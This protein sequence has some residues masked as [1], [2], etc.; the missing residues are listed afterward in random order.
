MRFSFWFL[1]IGMILAAP[2]MAQPAACGAERAS[3]EHEM[4][5]ARSK[6]QMLQRRQLAER[7][8]TLPAD[9]QPAH[10]DPSHA[11]DIKRLEQEIAELRAA[12]D[13]AEA[14]LHKLKS[15]SP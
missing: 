5:V 11:A 9:C 15:E 3:I 6:G 8:A 13:Q 14:Q 12:L 2:A 4:E 10:S 7:L 1:A